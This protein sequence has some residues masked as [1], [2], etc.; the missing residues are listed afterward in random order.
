MPNIVLTYKCNLKCPYCFANEFVNKEDK[1][2]T[3]DNFQK[4]LEFI[5]RNNTMHLGLIGG[6]PLLHPEFSKIL[7]IIKNDNK[8]KKCIIYTNGLL[9]K[10][11]IDIIKNDKFCLLINCNSPEDI[12]EKNY[13]TILEN[14]NICIKNK[15]NYIEKVV[16]GINIYKKNYDY[17]FIINILKKYKFKQL[18]I[19]ITVPNS[20]DCK[21]ETSLK[22][23]ND[24]K[25]MVLDL[26]KEAEKINV[27]PFFDCNN[28]PVCLL[29]E[30]EIKYFEQL[31]NKYKNDINKNKV[32]FNLLSKSMC[33]PVID[34]LPDLN[35]IRC[36]GTSNISKADIKKFDNIRNI[37]KYYTNKLDALGINIPTYNECN[38]CSEFHESKCLSG[39]LSYKTE[40]ISLIKEFL[41]RKT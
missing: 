1:F 9:I 18:R 40:K 22:S 19:S 3:L 33:K 14:I 41:N 6:E 34:I 38:K 21:K 16:P 4:A 8:I 17:S 31:K 30:E 15:K 37:E 29:T 28:L 39:C 32:I 10:N 5:K 24:N 23:F 20:K 35:V 2:I 11:Y 25:K 26:I 7:K 13:N 36:F 12:G 27:L